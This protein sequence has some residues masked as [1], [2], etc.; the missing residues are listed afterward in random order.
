MVWSTQLSSRERLQHRGTWLRAQKIW[1]ITLLWMTAPNPSGG[2]VLGRHHPA[3]IPR[4]ITGLT[5]TTTRKA[6]PAAK[7]GAGIRSFEMATRG[8]SF[9]MENNR[10]GPDESI[11]QINRYVVLNKSFLSEKQL[12][13][14]L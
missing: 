3:A 1:A 14:I 13:K 8:M 5:R 7:A 12:T 9:A 4:T 2:A 11:S 6:L 10:M